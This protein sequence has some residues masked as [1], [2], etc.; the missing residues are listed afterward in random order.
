MKRSIVRLVTRPERIQADAAAQLRAAVQAVPD[1]AISAW[2]RVRALKALAS[3]SE[4]A[5]RAKGWRYSMISIQQVGAVWDALD[6]LPARDR[7]KLVHRAFRQ[8]LLNLETDTGLVLLSRDEFA[9]KLGVSSDHAS[10]ALSVLVRLGVLFRQVSRVPGLR[11]PGVVTFR[12]N[13][14]VAW[15]GSLEVRQAEAAKRP[16]PLLKLMEA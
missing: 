13:P 16:G 1:E 15:N 10:A 2:D 6:R 14:D 5:Q 4:P 9:E 8:V 12:V 11:G 3:V 7:P